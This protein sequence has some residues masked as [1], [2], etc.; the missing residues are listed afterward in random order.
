MTDREL[1]PVAR[2]VARIKQV[3][4]GWGKTATIG[5]MRSDWDALFSGLPL[6]AAMAPVD[7]GGVP[8]AWFTAPG[9]RADKVVLYFHGGG[10]SIGSTRSHAELMSAMAAAGG[11]RVLGI[12][13]RLL[14]EHR[15]PAPMEDASAAYAWLLTQGL[16]PA[17]I[18][19]AGDSAGGGLVAVLLLALRDAGQV[20]PAAGVM[21]SALTDFS[22]SGASYETRSKLDPIHQR[23]LIQALARNY[24]GDRFDPRDPQ[25]SPLFAD[26]HGLPPLLVQA[27]DCETVLSDTTDFADKARAAG[28]P[29]EL[30]VWPD[31]IHVF[32]QFP[33]ELVQAREAVASIGRFLRQTWDRT[34][35]S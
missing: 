7:V 22:A 13:Y 8:G 21:M 27:G 24:L 26:L 9:G 15:C 3:Y 10:F 18:V 5:Q 6:A 23:A 29:V 28:V 16:R 14:P 2:V 11:C 32:Q 31:M 30:E 12:D 20:V 25:V 35:P 4:R 34:G 1:T 33:D 19:L 17:D